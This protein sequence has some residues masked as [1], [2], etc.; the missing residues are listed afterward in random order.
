[1]LIVGSRCGIVEAVAGQ[2]SGGWEKAEESTAR[3]SATA[4]MQAAIMA[5]RERITAADIRR[6]CRR[7][8]LEPAPTQ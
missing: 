1:M 7:G 5:P 2:I 4:E 8:A 6:N 3:A